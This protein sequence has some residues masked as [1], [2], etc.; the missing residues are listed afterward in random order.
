MTEFK[1]TQKMTQW[2]L[3]AILL[4][5]T[6]VVFWEIVAET[7]S[8]QLSVAEFVSSP[9]LWTSALI[10]ILVLVFFYLLSLKTEVDPEKIHI[11]YFPLWRTHICWN[12]VASAE[13]IKYGFVGYGI[14]FSIRH[15]TVYN[16][17]GNRGLQIVKKNGSKILVG[18]QRPEELKAAVDKLL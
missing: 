16:A 2:W 13:L 14:R 10:L 12:D 11:H 18:T 17:K 6:G 9:Q 5:T 15:G 3:W 1:E 4:G 7:I 8:R